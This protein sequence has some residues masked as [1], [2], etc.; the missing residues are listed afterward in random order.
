MKS[1]RR[2]GSLILIMLAFNL[3]GC[4]AKVEKDEV[5]NP[6]VDSDEQGVMEA[7]GFDMKAPQDAT[8]VRYS[9]MKESQIAQMTYEKDQIS[10]VYRMKATPELVDISGMN[11][12]W[13]LVD[14]GTVGGRNAVYY[15]FSTA[16][17]KTEY[18]DSTNTVQVVNWYDD[19]IGVSYSL[20]ASG[21]DLNGM[22][23]QVY[24]E[25]LYAPLQT[26]V[27][28]DEQKDREDEVKEYFLGE[29][30]RSYDESSI[31]IEEAQD[32]QYNVDISI[33]RL[34][35]LEDG[36]GTF[37]DHVMNFTVIDPSENELQG[38]IYRD[39]D[40]TLTI[41]ITKST[42]EYLPIGEKLTDFGK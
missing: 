37:E 18:I 40:N 10:W 6:W 35:A 32:G 20:S 13:S 30:I 17:E 23:I 3:W 2:F 21:K 4:G 5:T 11:Y 24:A 36:V 15:S 19:L 42:W 16:T 39:T 31:V 1:I 25:E 34:C 41:E 22:D 33:I 7:I 14:N 27:T 28:D 12:E 38:K 8:D 29:H 9:Y 26:E